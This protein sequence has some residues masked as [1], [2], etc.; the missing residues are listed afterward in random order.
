MGEQDHAQ[1]RIDGLLDALRDAETDFRRSYS[2]ILEVVNLLEEEKAGAV[3]GFGTTTQLLAGVL[4][5][6]KGEARTRVEHAAL[7]TPR[8]SL[9]GQMLAPSLPATAAELTAGAISPTHVRVIAAAM[10][11][12]PDGTHPETAAQA[13]QTLATAARRFDPSALGTI[14]ERLLAH[15]DPD[16]PEPAEEP[17]VMREL[18]VRTGPDG[19]VSLTGKLDVEGGARVLEVLGSLNGPRPPVEGVPDTRSESRRNA[20]ALVEA[21]TSLLDEGELPTRGGQR[22]H[23]VLT[24]D[25][26]DLIDGLGVAT[27][28]T[29]GCLCAGEARRLGCDA[30]IIPMVLGGDS[31]PLDVG[32]H[33]RLATAALRDALASRDQGCAFPACQRPPRYCHAHHIVSWLDG[34]ETKLSNMCLLCEYHHTIVH[35]QG[36]HIRLDGR[37]RPEFIPPK[38]IDPARRPLHDPLRQ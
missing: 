7:L 27:L 12:I 29:G 6:S 15:L 2:R 20:D 28:D 25:L 10:G 31:M 38:A 14:A 18:R 1:A 26:N 24:M 16:G 36:W 19:V 21:M 33:Q 5:L 3:A 32:R 37:S 13:E 8:R 17:D 9:T 11:R 4:N 35:R 22:P 34:G 30:T 23:L